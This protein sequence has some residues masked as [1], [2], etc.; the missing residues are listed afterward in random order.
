MVS[1]VSICPRRALK[2]Q[3]AIRIGLNM[4]GIVGGLFCLSVAIF[5]LRVVLEKQLT[6]LSVS[7]FFKESHPI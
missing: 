5:H 4:I 2:P 7:I 6:M 1:G 3:S